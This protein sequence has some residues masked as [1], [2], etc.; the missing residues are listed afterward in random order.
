MK[1]RKTAS[2]T[3]SAIM[4]VIFFYGILRFPDGPI[5][6]CGINRYCGKQGQPHTLQQYRAFKS[7]ET[8]FVYIWPV[9]LLSL[10]LLNVS[11][12][13]ATDLTG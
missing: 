11:V 6:P 2:A 5:H 10:W 9:G 13:A 1:I 8:T 4:L 7:W 12:S 3:I